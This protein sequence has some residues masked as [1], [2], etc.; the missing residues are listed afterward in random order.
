MWLADSEQDLAALLNAQ[1]MSSS[2]SPE[3]HLTPKCSH[4]PTG[5]ILFLFGNAA[6][7]RGQGYHDSPSVT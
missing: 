2:E 7:G 5:S 6:S 3:T 1:P 4:P